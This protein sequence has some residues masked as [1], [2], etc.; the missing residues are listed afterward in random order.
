M[1]QGIEKPSVLADGAA[2]KSGVQRATL[3]VLW[4][5]ERGA[6]SSYDSTSDLPVS[7]TI[8]SDSMLPRTT[9]RSRLNVI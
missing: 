4:Q 3:V 7:R 6:A 1:I 2:A 8:L 5:L 9:P